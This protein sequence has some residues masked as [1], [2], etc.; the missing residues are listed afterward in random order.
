MVVPVL[1]DRDLD[2]DAYLAAE[3]GL[4]L[5]LSRVRQRRFQLLDVAELALVPSAVAPVAHAL[6]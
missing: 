4:I 3:V 5:R 2:V 1:A 6:P